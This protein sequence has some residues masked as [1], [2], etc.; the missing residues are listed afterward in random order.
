MTPGDTKRGNA[1]R[2][3]GG[4]K[5]VKSRSLFGKVRF[6]ESECD[7]IG[8]GTMLGFEGRARAV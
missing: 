4:A 6:R 5:G 1:L 7:G 8:M 2:G 3:I